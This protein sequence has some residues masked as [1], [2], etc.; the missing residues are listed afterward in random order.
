ML[1]AIEGMRTE[2]GECMERMI[3]VEMHIS[4]T[5]DTVGSLQ[6]KVLSLETRN[7]DMEVKIIDSETRSRRNNLRLV[8]A[9]GRDACSFLKT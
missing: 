2:V 8:K 9:E 3:N 7:R 5:E 4:D 1:A 6:A